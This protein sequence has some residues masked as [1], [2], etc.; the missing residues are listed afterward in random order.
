MTTQEQRAE[1]SALA[2][3]ATSGA[4]K[5]RISELTTDHEVTVYDADYDCTGV[6]AVCNSGL[7]YDDNEPNAAF[8]AAARTA[9][10]ALLADVDALTAENANAKAAL[11]TA[12]QLMREANARADALAAVWAQVV[13]ISDE[14]NPKRG[15]PFGGDT[16]IAAYNM[17][18]VRDVVREWKEAQNA[19]LE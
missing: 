6:V 1:W 10:P 8:I 15:G 16:N 4:W 17:S 9:V 5:P 19:V 12:A 18:R 7:R 13:A 14:M 2:Q 3:A 11:I